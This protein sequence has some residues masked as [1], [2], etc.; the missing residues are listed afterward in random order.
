MQQQLELIGGVM[1]VIALVHVVFPRYFA[2]KKELAGLSLV[3]RQMMQV[4]AFFIALTVLLMGLLC[5]TS[6]E[7]LVRSELGRRVAL[8]LG[9]FW[10]VRLLIQLFG[11]SPRLWRGKRLETALHVVATGVWTWF[12]VVFLRVG[13]GG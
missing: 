10:T 3:N 5:L 8:G 9:V 13:L 2:W 6:S 4:H 12:S 7:A 11:Y 1:I